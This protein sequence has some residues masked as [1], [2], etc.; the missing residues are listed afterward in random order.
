MLHSDVAGLH[1]SPLRAGSTAASLGQRQ[2]LRI[3][4]SGRVAK[5]AA[6]S[7]SDPVWILCADSV[8][9]LG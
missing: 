1:G 3:L 8:R 9:I 2:F 7:G 6:K 4:E 5:P